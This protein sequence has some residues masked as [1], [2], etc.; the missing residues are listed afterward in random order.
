MERNKTIIKTSIKGIIT[1][2]FLVIFKM[3]IGLLANSIAII[4]DA[5]NNLTDVLS[6]TITIIGTHLSN[7]A[8]DKEHPY[9]HGRI[10]Y[11]TSIIIGVIILVAGLLSLKESVINI[12]NPTPKKYTIYTLIIIIVAI[13]VKLL[14]GSYVK[15]VGKN[16]NSGCLIA[17]GTDALFDAILSLGTLLAAIIYIL[18]KLNIEGIIGLLISLFIIKSSIELLKETT[19]ELIGTRISSELSQKIKDI[20]TSFK[21]V[22]GAYDL[23]LHNYGPIYMVGSIHIEVKDTMTAREIHKLSKEIE[24]IIFKEFSIILTI[25]IYASNTTDKKSKKIKGDIE[26]IISKYKEILQLH[27]FYVDNNSKTINFDI[28][29]DFDTP[30]KEKIKKQIIKEIKNIYPDYKFYVVIDNDY[31]D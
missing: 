4:L 18:F 27:G 28:I 13:I 5:I 25:G 3:I 24:T 29:I 14:L 7:K 23:I 6:S 8:P 20:I 30:D 1:N 12:I 26:K 2:I 31:S 10:E 9:G 22:E 21:E 11:F 15:K 16:I 17:S 19:N